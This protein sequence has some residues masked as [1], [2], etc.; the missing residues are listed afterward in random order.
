LE[1]IGLRNQHDLG[2]NFLMFY[3]VLQCILLADSIGYGDICPGDL[4]FIGRVFFVL[5]L[6][7]GLGMFC[8]PIMDLASSWKKHVPGGFPALASLT[9]GIGAAIFSLEGLSQS[10]AIY[11]SIVTGKR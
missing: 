5:F 4:T 2:H 10:D 1:A 9:V 11:A 6:F 7:S 3:C 8:G